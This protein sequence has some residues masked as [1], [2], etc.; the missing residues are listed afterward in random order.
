MGGVTV[1]RTVCIPATAGTNSE[2]EKLK[3]RR[4]NSKLCRQ[5]QRGG[6]RADNGACRSAMAATICLA[7]AA[8]RTM[9]RNVCHAIFPVFFF[10]F[11]F[12]GQKEVPQMSLCRCHS[13]SVLSTCHS[14]T[15]SLLCL[16]MS[17][18]DEICHL[19]AEWVPH[20]DN[21]LN[22]NTQKLDD[23]N[24]RYIWPVIHFWSVTLTKYGTVVL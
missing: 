22:F 17:R 2:D 24:I 19:P 4:G 18:G 9:N 15:G 20:Q 5:P 10:R 21:L 14:L 12:S 23:K 16:D 8:A 3:R 13:L 6:R 11:F 7:D 1:T